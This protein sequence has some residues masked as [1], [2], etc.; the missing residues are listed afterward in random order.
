MKYRLTDETKVVSGHTLHRIEALKD[1][2]DVH[3]GDK[4]GFVEGEHNLSQSGNCWVYDNACV[5]DRAYVCGSAYVYD[6]A[7]VYGSANVY[8]SAK[9]CGSAKVYGSANVSDSAKVYGSAKVCGR[10][11]LCGSAKVYGSAYVYDS[12][13]VCGSANIQSAADYIY[14]KGLGSEYRGTTVFRD[15]NYGVAV[16]CGCFLG[17]L[18]EF[19]KQ[20]KET[21]GDSKFAAEYL[22]LVELIKIHFEI[23][24]SSK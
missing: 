22:K 13:Y 5:Y 14:I 20:V 11:T 7:K 10:A 21:H 1:F 16:K 4:G 24:E 17:S 6:S 2:A 12:A 15:R 3:K 8:V 9:V 18:A 19:E 23:D